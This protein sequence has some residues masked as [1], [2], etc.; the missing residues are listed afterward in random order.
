MASLITFLND[1][2]DIKIEILDCVDD[3]CSFCP[4]L[5]KEC[6]CKNS[7]SELNIKKRDALTIDFLDLKVREV[8]SYLNILNR[9]SDFLDFGKVDTICKD[10]EWQHVCLFYSKF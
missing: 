10:C 5:T 2:Q 8:Y 1:N 9:I 6:V 7:E 4:N 3:I